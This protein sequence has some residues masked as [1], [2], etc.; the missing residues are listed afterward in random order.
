MREYR[1][2]EHPDH[3]WHFRHG[4]FIARSFVG[5]AAYFVGY[6][7]LDWASYIYPVTPLGI[8]PWN[9][10]PGLSLFLLL[11]GG[12]RYWPML[13]VSA[14]AADLVVRGAHTAA[15]TLV[16]AAVIITATYATTAYLLKVRLRV[17]PGVE[18]TRDLVMIIRS[19]HG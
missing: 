19:C 8:T 2:V 4:S 16:A 5:L 3:A 1:A 14:L 17:Q 6:I 15:G 7:A 18:S 11:W 10:P 9:P 13:F 12:L